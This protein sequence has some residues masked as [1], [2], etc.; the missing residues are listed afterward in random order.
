LTQKTTQKFQKG[1]ANIAHTRTIVPPHPSSLARKKRTART[2][3]D[4]CPSSLSPA[5]GSPAAR[6][7]D[8]DDDDD[9]KDKDKD[10]N[11]NKD[12]D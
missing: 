12:D 9:D 2:R 8:D 5:P 1:H 10:Y 6:T 3:R 7:A 11:D 4:A